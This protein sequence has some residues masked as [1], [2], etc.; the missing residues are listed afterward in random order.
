MP[1]PSSSFKD[2]TGRTQDSENILDT[3]I[4][5]LEAKIKAAQTKR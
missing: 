2:D 1:S 4:A 5:M 3:M